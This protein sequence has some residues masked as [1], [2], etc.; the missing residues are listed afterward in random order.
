MRHEDRHAPIPA[1]TAPPEPMVLP[2]DSTIVAWNEQ[3][4]HYERA[5]LTEQRPN[6]FIV[7]FQTHTAGVHVIYEKDKIHIA[8]HSGTPTTCTL[9]DED[10]VKPR[11]TEAFARTDTEL[12]PLIKPKQTE[13]V[14]EAI[15]IVTDMFGEA[16]KSQS[17]QRLHALL[18]EL[19]D[20]I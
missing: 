19:R 16:P 13:T 12:H 7:H 1:T 11:I 6:I 10:D 5:T 4:H 8:H 2:K 20:S 14:E 9:F 15:K 17:A 18:R 3:T